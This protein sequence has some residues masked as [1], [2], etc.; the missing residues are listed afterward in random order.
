MKL[1]KSANVDLASEH[2]D[3]ENDTKSSCAKS[4]VEQHWINNIYETNVASP[5]T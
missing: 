2:T 1:M 5:H 4:N 3:D